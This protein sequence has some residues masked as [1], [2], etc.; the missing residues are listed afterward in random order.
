MFTILF[1][2]MLYV[3]IIFIMYIYIYTVYT[4][5]VH[6]QLQLQCLGASTDSSGIWKSPNEDL[7]QVTWGSTI[8]F[9]VILEHMLA[10]NRSLGTCYMYLNGPHAFSVGSLESESAITDGVNDQILL[11]RVC[12]LS[13]Y[14]W[15]LSKCTE[16][17]TSKHRPHKLCLGSVETEY[18]IMCVYII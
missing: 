10:T 14:Y 4:T 16:V 17:G 13:G 6:S 3:H 7:L 2:R 9:M 8:C 1:I 12:F 11:Q 18:M 15:T 5:I